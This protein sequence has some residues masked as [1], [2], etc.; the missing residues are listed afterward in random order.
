MQR[1]RHLLATILGRSRMEQDLAEELRFHIQSRAEHLMRSGLSPGEAERQARIEFGAVEAYKE[2]CRE[3]NGL[4]WFDELRGNVR[5]TLRALRKNPGFTLAAVL[6]LAVGIG[7]NTSAFSSVISLV[8]HPFPYPHLD[9]VMTLWTT[10]LKLGSPRRRLAAGNFFDWKQNNRTFEYLSAYRGWNATLTG[11]DE[12]RRLH[13]AQVSVDFFETFAMYTRSGRSFS[14]GDMQPGRDGVAIVSDAFWK[15]QLASVPDP[16]GRTISLDTRTYTVIG[17]MP[18]EFDFQLGTELWTP[19]ALTPQEKANR[20]RTD[21]YVY[22]RLKPGTSMQQARAEITA[23]SA[24]LERRYPKTNAGHGVMINPLR[25]SIDQVTGRFTIILLG[26]ATFVLLLACA[27]VANLQLARSTARQREIGLRAAL[28]ASRFRIARELLTESVVIGMLGGSVGMLLANWDLHITKAAIPVQVFHWVAGLKT[29]HMD[30]STVVF[31]FALSLA[32]GVAC[33]LP[34]IYHL[35][36]Q[37]DRTGLNDVLK[38]GGRTSSSGT[39]RSR[40]RSTL[41]VVEVALSLVLLIGAGLMVR[42]FQRILALNLGYDPKNMLITDVWLSA[43]NYPDGA[44]MAHF[45]EQVLDGLNTIP[46]VESAAGAGDIGGAA[47][48]SIEGHE[49]HPSDPRPNISA[50][51]PGYFHTMRIPLRAGRSIGQEDGPNAPPVVVVSEAMARHFWPGLNPIGRRIRLKGPGSPWLTVAGVC[52]D[53]KDWFS[54][55][56]ELAVYVSYRQWPNIYMELHVRTRQDPLRLA[57]S[58]RAQVRMVDR[59]QAVSNI[60]TEEQSLAEETSGVRMASARMSVYAAISLLLAVMGCYAVGAFS[61]ARRTQEIGI[62]MTLG[63]TRNNILGMVLTQTARMT[64]IGLV[65]G[66]ALAI[67]MTELMSHALYNVVSVEPMTFVVLTA[68]LAASAL[69]AGYI[70]AYRAAR[71]DPMAALRND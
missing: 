41:V 43:T 66:L 26:A 53:L 36:R 21:L 65:V 60:N 47:T 63:A 68:L 1:L 39:S 2:S 8:L 58:V 30:A 32:A 3:A 28:G 64:A 42:T 31:G 24:E 9:R 19:L 22:G 70:P 52:G 29:W 20:E 15:S 16:L 27:N 11:V 48:V 57:S 38:E 18:E 51:S 7:V 23:L 71:I 62:R 69:M 45:F 59:N 44:R 61:V 4:A 55:D 12:P 46:G 67:A 49:A 5:Y 54:G 35:L 34:A 13:A 50:I 10:D 25:E 14:H 17:V 37:H 56:P 33:S 6:S 40:A